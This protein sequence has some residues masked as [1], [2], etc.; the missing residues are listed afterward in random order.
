MQFIVLKIG[1]TLPLHRF[2]YF[3]K[4]RQ[5]R[6]RLQRT[7]AKISDFQTTPSPCPGVSEFQKQHPPPRT[8]ASGFFNVYTFFNFYTFLFFLIKTKFIAEFLFFK[9]LKCWI[10]LH[11][12]NKNAIKELLGAVYKGRPPKSRLFKP[13]P[14]LVRVSEFPKPPPPRTSTSG[15]FNFY[16]FFNIYTF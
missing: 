4:K 9:S 11:L 8:S 12:E 3:R 10:Q 7:S 16:T 6:G 13:P 2:K 1:I 15:F 14:P 5:V